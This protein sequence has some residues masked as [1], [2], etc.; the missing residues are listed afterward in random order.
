MLFVVKTSLLYNFFFLEGAIFHVSPLP[1]ALHS[2]IN[3]SSR[4]GSGGKSFLILHSI[5]N[6]LYNYVYNFRACAS[7]NYLFISVTI[8]LRSE[9]STRLETSWERCHFKIIILSQFWHIIGVQPHKMSFLLPPWTLIL[10][11]FSKFV[12][13]FLIIKC[14]SSS[15]FCPRSS[16]SLLFIRWFHSI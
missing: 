10:Y 16:H 5:A 2:F 12:F 8:F 4:I 11:L 14:F 15:K 1:I 7:H 6:L 13:L 3:I 9:Y